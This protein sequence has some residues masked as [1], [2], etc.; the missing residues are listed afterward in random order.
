MKIRPKLDAETQ[1][2]FDAAVGS[3]ARWDGSELE[4]QRLRSTWTD[5]ASRLRSG[6]ELEAILRVLADLV[7]QGWKLETAESG[8]AAL[9]QPN[10]ENQAAAERD[11]VRAQEELKRVEQL[12]VDSVRRFISSMERR[13]LRG[14]SFTSIFS[15]M[16]DGRELA[17]A[18][19]SGVGKQ[20]IRPYIQ[21][22]VPDEA[23]EHTGLKLSDI[24]RYFRHTWSNQYT[25]VPGR[26]MSFLVRDASAPK[27]PI[28]GIFA[29]SSAVVQI[30]IR[31]TH[32]GWH[33]DTVL[34][35]LEEEAEAEVVVVLRDVVTRGI[36]EELYTDDLVSL[37]LMES[38][39]EFRSPTHELIESLREAAATAKQQHE[40]SPD[41]SL[42]KSSAG[43]DDEFWRRRAETSLY[44]Y[45][46]LLQLA[47][48][49]EARLVLGRHLSE[50][51]SEDEIRSLLADKAGVKTLR[52]LIRRAKAERVGISLADLSVC[53]AVPPY[54]HLFG[55]K[56]VAMLAA[57][58][59]VVRTYADRYADASSE[60]ASAMAGRSIV[61]PPQLVFIGTTSLYGLALNQYTRVA[62]PCK[63]LGGTGRIRY[64]KLGYSQA[65]GTS[66]YG[67]ETVKALARASER[68]HGQ[69]RVNHIFGEGTS[70]KMRMIREGLESVGLPA[71]LLLQHGRQRV[72]YGVEL[73]HN[74]SEYLLGLRDTPA[75]KFSLDH[76]T[77]ASNRIGEHWWERWVHPR[78]G[79]PGLLERVEKETL[80]HPIR[81]GARVVL[82]HKHVD[83]AELFEG[84]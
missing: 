32:L 7:A 52:R 59:Q 79:K 11:R 15:L 10:P 26:S 23:C 3:L 48:F 27:H 81:H 14:T 55:G 65:Y 64:R 13:Q 1:S 21:E 33:P 63:P 45:K 56:L 18:V 34:D 22:V 80:R 69:Q 50:E 9:H 17:A 16:R 12:R 57:S 71:D 76:P 84:L 77:K 25:S 35:R 24:W 43:V 5:H 72:V 60:I 47:E 30:G 62:I 41:L 61:R 74:T 54:N 46:R 20:V 70:P 4:L 29:L 58:P 82:P 73:S 83:H 44:R 53:G 75:Y 8:A 40:R 2:Y 66:H 31:D 19:R 36:N 28:I 38:R 39:K 42:K 78:L 49:L 6:P 67:R 37:G 68:L 51:P